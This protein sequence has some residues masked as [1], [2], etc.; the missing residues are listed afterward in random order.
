M[1]LP[2]ANAGSGLRHSRHCGVGH[3]HFGGFLVLHVIL[4]SDRALA[5][6][7][8]DRVLASADPSGLDTDQ[9]DAAT[10]IGTRQAYARIAHF[11]CEFYQSMNAICLADGRT[12]AFPLSQDEDA[13]G[14]STVGCKPVATGDV[15]WPHQFAEAMRSRNPRLG[16]APGDRRECSNAEA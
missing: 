4:G 2:P 15:R 16:K 7:S 6:R 12:I 9:I 1:R 8:L 13:Q 10:S 3:S 14:L 5:K 11:L